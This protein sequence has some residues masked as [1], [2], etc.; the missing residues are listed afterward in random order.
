MEKKIVHFTYEKK[1]APKRCTELHSEGGRIINV[2]K[3]VGKAERLDG[4]HHDTG[5]RFVWH[6]SA[7]NRCIRLFL[8]FWRINSIINI[9]GRVTTVGSFSIITQR[10]RFGSASDAKYF[11]YLREPDEERA[12]NESPHAQRGCGTVRVSER[13]EEADRTQDVQ[14][15]ADDREEDVDR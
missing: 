5:E 9:I 4:R 11:P 12:H 3:P 1:P 15:W 8:P 10:E 6:R 14:R 13:W 2:A 7:I